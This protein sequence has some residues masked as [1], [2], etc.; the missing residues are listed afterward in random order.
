MSGGINLTGLPDPGDYN[1]GRGIVYFA[2]L[3]PTTGLPLE[4]RDLGNA[5]EFNLSLESETLEHQ[6][7]R[8]GLK[9]TDLEVIISLKASCSFALD[10]ANFDNLALYFQGETAS[11]VNPA[12][13][14]VGGTPG[15][16][17]IAITSQAYPAK[18][19]VWY[20]IR[21][22][23]GNR[24]YD[25]DPTKIVVKKATDDTMATSV[26][27]V[28][29]TQY[30]LDTKMG[31]IFHKSTSDVNLGTHPVL[32]YTLLADAGAKPVDE[33][34][35]LTKTSIKGALKFIAE[36]P[37]NNDKQYEYQF[38]KISVK[39]DGDFALISDE[40]TQMQFSGV[41]EKNELA[42]PSSP[43]LTIRTHADA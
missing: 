23:S 42:S 22:A 7:S 12:T 9:V 27:L 26:D 8:K 18:K 3:H 40:I 32:C 34:R 1:L 14:G 15:T 30:T 36:N 29:N 31:R 2:A 10:E 41:A 17:K 24:V 20:D 6:S 37:A 4:W 38:H 35:G 33:V 43:T 39:P 25:V 13:A 19:G 21:D 28:L 11:Y 16:T 5:P